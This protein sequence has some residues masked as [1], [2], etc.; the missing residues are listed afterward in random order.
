MVRLGQR[1]NDRYLVEELIGEGATSAVYRGTDTVLRRAVAIKVLHPHVHA[2]TRQRFEQE[3]QASAKLNHPNIMMIFDR[4]RDRDDYYLVVE[5]VRGKPLYEYIPCNPETAAQL[6]SQICLALDYAH[7]AGI[8]H[9]DIKPAN[10]YVTPENTIKIMDFG[11]AIPIDGSQKRLTAHGS[12]IGTPAYLSPEQAQGKP[13]D[14]RTDLYSLG[15]VLYEMVTGQLPFDADDITSILI[16]QVNKAP[17]PPSQLVRDLPHSLEAVILKA[18]EKKPEQRFST[19]LEMAAALDAVFKQPAASTGAVTMEARSKPRI[20]AVL[21]DDHPSLRTPLAAYLELSGEI[22]VVAEAGDGYEA[23]EACRQ[24]QPDVLLLDL[25]MPNLSGLDALPQIKRLSPNSKVLVLTAR[26]ETPYIMRAL[27]SGANGYILK[28]ATEQEVVS[29]VK[30]VYEG[31]TVLGQGVAERVVE[32]LRS[33]DRSDPLNEQEHAVLRCVAAGFEEND[34][35]AARLGIEES[36]V[37]R[38]LKNAIDKLG[39]K[40][41]SEA[42]LMALRAGWISMEDVR[43]LTG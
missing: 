27:R 9:R 24:H 38:L 15:V 18:L 6:G 12:I 1:L 4:G 7:R 8:I 35:I 11:L 14:P 25:N 37:P 17:V 43:N 30:D 22:V 16:Q 5:L 33:M 20:R 28:T 21:A 26:D 13:L 23:I 41:R 3:A 31:S 29:A 10:I 19:A 39:V 34:Q 32:G 36:S 42:A 40:S 2:T